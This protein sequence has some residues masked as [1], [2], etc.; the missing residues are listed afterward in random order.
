MSGSNSIVVPG[1]PS[2]NRVPGVFAA[3][4]ASKANTGTIN[5][6]TI[7]LAQMLASGTATPG[8]PQIS[9]G[10]GEAQLSYGPGSG[11]ALAVERY[12]GID[13]VGELWCMPMSDAA[14]AA[15]AAG[16]ILFAG[17]STIAG[18][19]PL[20]LNGVYVGC[21]VNLGDTAT[22]IAANA[23]A[24]I[25]AYTSSLGNPLSMTAVAAA[26]LVTLT[27]R[28]GGTLGNTNTI[29]LSVLGPSGGQGQPGTTNVP[30]VTAT[31]TQFAGGATDPSVANAL[32]G[33]PVTPFDFIVCPYNDTASLNAVQAFLGDAAGRWNW[34]VQLFGGAFT[35]KGGSLS[36]RTTWSTLRNDQ[37]ASA[38]GAFGSP[39]PDWA[40]AVDYAAACAVSIRAN[41]TLPI[42]GLV[43]GAALNVMAPP[44]ANQDG[45]PARQTLLFD[46]MTT[47]KVDPAGVVHVDRAITTYQFNAAGG[48]DNSY[49]NLNV[50]Y[51]LMA[52]IRTV[53]TMIG[54]NFNQSI[55]V[56][57]GSRI[58]VGS[59]MVTSQTILFAVISLY[60]Q[61]ADG[62]VPGAPAGL[63][64]NAA[65]FAAAATAINAGGGIVK[66]LLPVQLG[67]QLIAVAINCQFSSP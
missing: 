1:Y 33:L 42:G 7:I 34:S 21:P 61:I 51:Q 41:P 14:G 19:I 10:T 40:W 20:Y 28:N 66:M 18:T 30:G 45:F 16:S 27:A 49:L 65:A 44:L 55:L 17:P 54:S 15:K 37:H 62:G 13:I 29:L 24:T 48:P 23:A 47:Y 5:Q 64:Q 46:G 50:P 60:T 9:Q 35:A 56:V 43:T 53:E 2:N 52:F 58:P 59:G 38:I 4:D 3:M 8:L 57:D 67:S 32:V 36:A 39:S 11:M 22:T 25:N 31:I 63:V 12:R 6:R 26:G